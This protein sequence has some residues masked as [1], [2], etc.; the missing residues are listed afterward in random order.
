[1]ETKIQ[2]ASSNSSTLVFFSICHL[3]ET[4]PCTKRLGG[5]G[6][7]DAASTLIS[8]R[9]VFLSFLFALVVLLFIGTQ[10]TEARSGCCSHHGGVCGCGCCD[11]SSLSAICAPYYPQCST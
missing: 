3:S 4:R 9:K 7:I 2:G 1:M 5:T 8:M 10:T 6:I 11:G